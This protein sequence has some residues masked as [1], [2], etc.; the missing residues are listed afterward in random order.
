VVVVVGGMGNLG[1]SI[2]ASIFI[3]LLESLATIWVNP[4]QAVIVSF[5]AL[6]LTLLVRPTG[7]FVP[8]PK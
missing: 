7:L 4:T 1:G 6:I 3:S 2:L 5:V 8:T